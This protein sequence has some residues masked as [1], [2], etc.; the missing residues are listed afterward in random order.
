MNVDIEIKK[1]LN[2]FS[3]PATKT[4]GLTLY[5]LLEL[6]G[7]SD[8][9]ERILI[10]DKSAR[11]YKETYYNLTSPAG[12][13]VVLEFGDGTLVYSKVDKTLSFNSTIHPFNSFVE[14]TA[15]DLVAG[16]N[17]AAF[18]CAPVGYSA[19]DLLAYLEELNISSISHY[20]AQT[21]MMKTVVFVNG[22]PGGSNFDIRAGE[23][24]FIYMKLLKNNF[25][26]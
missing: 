25:K 22:Q 24:Y 5:E 10:Y 2:M 11:V 19:Y 18:P 16:M 7:P 9:I 4:G 3:Y 21:G 15:I 6:L 17:V 26:P 8:Q 13:N 23:A 14:C 20:D 12:D 1:G